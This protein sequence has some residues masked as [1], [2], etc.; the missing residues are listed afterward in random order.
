[1]S[2]SINPNLTATITFTD[3]IGNFSYSLVDTTGAL[4]TVNGTGTFVAGQPI[5]LNGFELQLE[6]RAQGRRHARPSPGPRSRPATTATPTRCSRC[7]TRPSSASGRSRP[8]S[9]R[10]GVNVTDAYASALA[11]IGVRVQSASYAADQSAAIAERRED[12]GRREVGRQPRRGSGAPDPVPAELPGRGQD[13]AGRAV[14]LRHRCCRSADNERSLHAHQHRQRLRQ[15]HR[16]PLAP[17]GRADR[18]CRTSSRPASAIS[19]A[20][21]DPAAAA[22]AERATA[23]IEPR[24]DE[25][26]RASR[27][28]RSR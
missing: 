13:A 9:S 6:R 23:S 8:A 11:A 25:P 12:G 10:A 18:R 2:A 15:R 20:S 16:H 27:R 21:D 7:A 22:R 1:M 19:R 5:A 4:P 3:N 17:P 14:G 28:A 24:R 26:A